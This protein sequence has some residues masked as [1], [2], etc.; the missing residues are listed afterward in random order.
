MRIFNYKFSGYYRLIRDGV[1]Q[2]IE[3]R[4]AGSLLG[5]L[6]AGVYPACQLAI[7][8]SVYAFIFK[9]RA[10]G[11]DTPSYVL[12]IF[13]GLVPVMMFNEALIAATASMGAGKTLVANTNYPAEIIPVRSVLA[14][15]VPGLIGLIITALYSISLG[16]LHWSSLVCIPLLW[17]LLL[18]MAIGIGSVFSVLALV[19]KD[20][21]IGIGLLSMLL[22]ITSPF[23]YTLEMV[24]GA[25]KMLIYFNPLTYF[26]LA[27]QNLMVFDA[28]P[29]WIHIA[30][31]LSMAIAFGIGG[32]LLFRRVM[33]VFIDHA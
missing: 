14:S 30:G 33:P 12:L 21:L 13:S 6:W 16:G 27:F 29:E 2:D 25:L 23:A 24:P 5:K 17:C 22:M 9:I 32:F 3:N 28:F 19:Y 7:F 31:A 20:I 15:Q 11:L 18:L 4:Y 8:A 1:R 10:P 26:V